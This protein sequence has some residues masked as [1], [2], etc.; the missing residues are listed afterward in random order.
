MNELPVRLT[1]REQIMRNIKATFE[2]GLNT[3]KGDELTWGV[4]ER[5]PIT[6]RD[7]ASRDNA[8]GIFDT[9]ER[10]QEAV[11]HERRF[12]NVVIEFHVS[13]AEGDDP[14]V[15]LNHALGQVL[16]RMG[17]D[18]YRG[19]LALNTRE[20]GSELDIDG[21]FDK[22]VSGV[23]VFDVSYRCRPNDP[24]SRV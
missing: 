2:A 8:I 20:N 3:A 24:Y 12:V 11:G 1:V 7:L 5:K 10:V 14:G 15:F 19:G 18:I 4:V 16:L 17:R 13:L 9:S 6:K 21:A 23:V 22:Y